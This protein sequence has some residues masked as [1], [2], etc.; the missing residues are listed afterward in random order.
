MRVWAIKYY[1]KFIKT[2]INKSTT[3][4]LTTIDMRDSVVVDPSIDID[5]EDSSIDDSSLG[6]INLDDEN[7]GSS[8]IV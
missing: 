6:S 3:V 8:P 1:L 7:D 2:K 4:G 5:M